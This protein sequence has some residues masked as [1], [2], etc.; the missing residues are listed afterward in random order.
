ME[1]FF[2][3]LGLAVFAVVVWAVLLGFG[4]IIYAILTEKP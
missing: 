3:G 2:G 4:F 1:T